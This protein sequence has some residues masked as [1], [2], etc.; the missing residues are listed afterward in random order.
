MDFFTLTILTFVVSFAGIVLL[1]GFRISFVKNMATEKLCEEIVSGDSFFEELASIPRFFKKIFGSIY[2]LFRK[3]S[4]H[5]FLRKYFCYFSNFV[6][7][8]HSVK[9]NGCEGYWGEINENNINKE[10]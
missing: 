1:L 3:I 6:H 7:G 10:E 2:L 9:K 4:K 8:R 5:P